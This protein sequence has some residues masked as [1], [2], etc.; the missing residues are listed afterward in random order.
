[1]APAPLR[2]AQ[3]LLRISPDDLH[4]PV[5][6]GLEASARD[7]LYPSEPYCE[8]EPTVREWLRECVPTRAGVAEYARGLFPFVGWVPR[9]NLRWLFGDAIA[10]ESS[11]GDGSYNTGVAVY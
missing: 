7:A 3:N 6:T 9:Y 5:P 11:D 10:G 8:A 1:M 4:A 2:V